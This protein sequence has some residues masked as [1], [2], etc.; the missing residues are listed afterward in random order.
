MANSLLSWEQ[1]RQY[2]GY[3]NR[4]FIRNCQIHMYSLESHYSERASALDFKDAATP[5]LGHGDVVFDLFIE[6]R[7]SHLIALLFNFFKCHWTKI[8]CLHIKSTTNSV[9]QA[10]LLMIDKRYLFMCPY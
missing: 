7:F 6:A 9:C 8:I 10:F 1:R 3:V 4:N 2:Q 5:R